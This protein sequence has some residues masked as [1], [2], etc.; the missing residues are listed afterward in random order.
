MRRPDCQ[1]LRK[2]LARPLVPLVGV[3]AILA[4]VTTRAILTRTGGEVA[5]PLDDAFIHFQFAR[6]FAELRPFEYS[7]GSPPTPGATSLAW[8][9]ALAPFYLVGF[10]GLGLVW[11]AWTLG[12]V[13]LAL[14]A[15]DTWKAAE[16]LLSRE[17]A[18][19][20]AAMVLCFG[21]NI[22]FAASG[23]EVVPLAWLLIRTARRCAEWRERSGRA[24]HRE[25]LELVAL[26]LV[27]PA[28]R[29][30]GA[31]AAALALGT[32]S[33]S[34]RG[35]SRAWAALPL[36]GPLLPGVVNWLCTGEWTTTTATAKW[37]LLS[38]YP[39]LIVPT[40][41]YHLD[42]LFHTLLAG[43]IWSSVFLPRGGKVLAWLTLPA[44]LTTGLLR[45][46][47]W[48]ALAIV[49]VGL[50]IL[51]PT[52]YE[53]FLVNRLRY[54]WPFAAAWF[55]GLAS[56]ADG[57]GA[58]LALLRPRLVSVRGLVAGAFVGLLLTEVD[59]SIDDLAVSADAIRQQQV[60]LA[61]WARQELPPDARLGVNDAGAIAYLSG[62]Q[63][64]D[65][66]GL[67]TAGEAQYWAA[68]A[69][70]RFE[71]YEKLDRSQLPTHFLVYDEWFAVN[72]IL[73]EYLTGRSVL[74]ATILGG[75]TKNA[76][77]ARYQALGS[78]ELPNPGQ[79]HGK[80]VDRLDVSDLEDEQSHRYEIFW[81]TKVDN[82]VWNLEDQAADGGRGNRSLDRFELDCRGGGLLAARVVVEEPLLLT[83][84]VAGR[85]AGTLRAEPG[86]P[87]QDAW[88][89]LPLDL[90]DGRV[91]I[92]VE[93]PDTKVFAGLHYWSF[94]RR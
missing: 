72:P 86:Y 33:L 31:I 25:L 10:R 39:A 58:L 47:A 12:W 17:A 36:L 44:L 81:G 21:G 1:T 45:G 74:D 85:S 88:L 84:R 80:L 29:P 41:T 70:S 71:H 59:Q 7:L 23:M 56:L 63:T 52:T 2:L 73:G 65:V 43:E 26:A 64:F 14:L 69:G 55:L 18:L 82:L 87:W 57:T 90:A 83:V 77:V 13:S 38:P 40:I 53:S 67:T 32:L 68:G 11:V 78:A 79:P 66:V 28:M 4:V 76:Y 35:R 24:T 19:A 16:G 3:T 75:V 37:L 49:A 50:G 51:I 22:W 54:L 9:L 27:T 48:R 62:R 6:R 30:E 94:G 5:V 46:R 60:S 61:L 15:Y 42:L 92:E 89:P 20:A 91:P 34:P 8:P 93:A